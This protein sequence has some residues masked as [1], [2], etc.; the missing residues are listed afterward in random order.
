MFGGFDPSTYLKVALAGIVLL[1]VI[2]IGILLIEHGSNTALEGVN[3]AN[4][5]AATNAEGAA[6]NYDD[7][8]RANRLWDYGAGKCG[9][10]AKSS[11]N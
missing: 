3:R 5:K 7:C 4:E 9:R 1:I 8:M 6:L 10:S 11:W 2:F